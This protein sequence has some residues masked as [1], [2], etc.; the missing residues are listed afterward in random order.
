MIIKQLDLIAFGRFTDVS[1]DLSAGPRRFH[2]IYG[3]NESG[4]STSLRAITAL[5]YG[6]PTKS[7]DDFLHD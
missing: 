2:L 4:K 7:T 3:P 1:L 6:I 5:F